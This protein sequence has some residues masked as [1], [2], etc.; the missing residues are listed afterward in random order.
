MRTQGRRQNARGNRGGRRA[1]AESKLVLKR[2]EQEDT[3]RK[4]TARAEVEA[5]RA[6]LE[7]WMSREQEG[8][9]VGAQFADLTQRALA[10]QA[11][12]DEIIAEAEPKPRPPHRYEPYES[13]PTEGYTVRDALRMLDEGYAVP[14]I[15]RRTGVGYMYFDGMPLDEGGRLRPE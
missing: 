4:R 14:H 13:E 11:A 7:R 3:E 12:V 10:A 2:H 8:S 15:M 1:G 6:R 5:E 9:A